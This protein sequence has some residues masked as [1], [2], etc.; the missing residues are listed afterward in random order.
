M[1]TLEYILNKYKPSGELPYVVY[2]DSG[3]E[4][5][6]KLLGELG[7]NKGAEIG[8]E[9]GQFSEILCKNIPNLNL[10]CIDAWT[11]IPDYRQRHREMQDSFYEMTKNR[12]APYNAKIVKGFSLEAAKDVPDESLDFVFIDANHEFRSCTD[13]IS[14]WSKKVR[15]GGIVSGHDFNYF[16]APQE[17]IH[18]KYVVTAWTAA[19]DIKPWFVFDKNK[20]W[21][22]VKS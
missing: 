5:F 22:W 13:D 14:V 1:D 17:L 20:I 2:Q 16:R 19:Y 9:R 21:F 12:L 3:K 11:A 8:V 18:T 15:K 7:F 10:T 4:D 6:A